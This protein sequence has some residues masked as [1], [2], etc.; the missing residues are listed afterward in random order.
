MIDPLSLPP[1][2]SCRSQGLT[3]A[4][5]AHQNGFQKPSILGDVA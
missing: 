1:V 5:T 4:I 2:T 3:Q